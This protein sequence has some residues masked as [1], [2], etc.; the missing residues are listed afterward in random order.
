MGKELSV[1]FLARWHSIHDRGGRSRAVADHG[2]LF[3][4]LGKVDS[5]LKFTGDNSPEVHNTVPQRCQNVSKEIA[6]LWL[7]FTDNFAVFCRKSTPSRD[8]YGHSP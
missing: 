5:R 3:D 2:S 1:A 8:Y 4:E 6:T 7:S